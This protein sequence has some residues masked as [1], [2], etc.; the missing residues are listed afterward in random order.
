MLALLVAI[1]C[2][3][4][5]RVMAEDGAQLY[6]REPLRIPMREAGSRGLEALLVRPA[7][8]GRYPLALVSHGSPRS[9][10]DRP[11]M[12]PYGLL[13][14][15]MEFARR[16][17]AAVAVMRRGFGDS[18]GGFAE[19]AGGCEG[20]NYVAAE[21]SAVADLRATITYLGTRPDVDTKRILAVG[22]S[23]GGIATVALA[24]NPPDGLV[25]AIS[26]AGGRGSKSEGMVCSE[27]RLVGAFGTFGRTS[28]TP[29]LWIYADN[30]KFFGPQ[31]ARRMY[32]AFTAA[33]G[34]AEFVK[35]PAFATDG[36]ALFANGTRLWVPYV[37]AFLQKQQLVL[38]DGLLPVPLPDIPAP[39]GLD[40]NGRKAFGDY[41]AAGP[42][43]VFAIS[44]K[45]AYGWGGGRRNTNAAT[46][47]AME[48]CSKRGPGCRVVFV[49]E[50]PAKP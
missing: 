50:T 35:H 26:F 31:L 45:G 2:A 47:R 8:A 25:A 10:G 49:D 17:W 18:G 12:T 39:A 32:Q 16:G 3:P 23:A 37:D 21:R 40:D 9:A 20:A 28:H 27:D 15:M 6:V 30:D 34:Q 22:V 5:G 7:A 14:Q 41:L 11:G 43:K 36:H 46:Q 24:A 29:M 33:G 13:P 44:P 48:N 38:R 1:A 19:D 4:G 42:H